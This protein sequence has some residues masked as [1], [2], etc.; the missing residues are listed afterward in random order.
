MLLKKI[1]IIPAH[2]CVN[3]FEIVCML[4]YVTQK[5]LK[6]YLYCQSIYQLESNYVSI[7]QQHFQGNCLHVLF[8]LE[9]D[10][11]NSEAL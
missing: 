9:T 11:V 6:L 8:D 1:Y 5:G 10:Q 3:G 7:S 2:T 4:M